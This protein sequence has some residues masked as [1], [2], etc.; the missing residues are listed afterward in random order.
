MAARISIIIPTQRRPEPL[1]KA[2]RSAIAQTGVDPTELELIVADNDAKPSAQ[3]L[4]VALAARAAF[5]VVYVHEPNPGLAN[6]R[7]AALR[8]AKGELIA[9]LDD[10]EEAPPGWL[11]ALLAVQ[12]AV[13]ADVV[14][15]PVIGRAPPH[16]VEHRAYFERFFSR[17]DPAPAG[18]IDH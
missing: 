3:A 2:I 9:F 6:V 18:L 13:D 15:G 14:F 12:A 11:A 7:N 10:D 8:C 1:A 5:P 17:L 16:I 4:V